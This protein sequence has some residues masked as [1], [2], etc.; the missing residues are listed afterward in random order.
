MSK[1]RWAAMSATVFGILVL[2]APQ[3]GIG[4][5][6]PGTKDFDKSGP[7]G[8]GPIMVGGPM[9]GQPRK[10][11]KDFDK[12]GDGRL[13]T[14]ERKAA[15]E[16]L[17]KDGR[18][19]GGF[20]KG[21]FGPPGMRGKQDPPKPGPKVSPADV[22]AYPD[23]PLY[24]SGVLRT[25]FLEFENKDWEA[26]LQ[27]FHNTD[28]EVPATL[29]VDGKKYP[30]VG[31]RFRGMTSYGGVPAGY[32]RPLNLSL[33][34][35]APGQRLYGYKTLNLLNAHEDPSF[36]S[37]VLYS[38]I[39]RKHI[40]APKANLVKVVIN[41]ESWGVYVSAQQFDKVF[42]QENFKTDQG[43]RWKVG[44]GPGG[45]GLE[46]VGENVADYK[47]RFELKSKDD[48]KAWKALINLCKVL[49]QTPAEKLEEA[50]SP[51]ID[52]DGLLWFL[53]L[54]VALVNGDGYWSR[55]CDY[56]LFLD[57]KGKFHVVPHDM[58]E[59]F[60]TGG[61]PGGGMM[62]IR[63]SR[64]GEILA[65][66]LQDMLG[67]TADQKKQVEALQRETEEKLA[68]ILTADQNKQV[69][70]MRDRGP[71]GFVFPGGGPGGPGGFGPKG[72]PPPGGPAAFV[73]AGAGGGGIDLDPLV[74]LTDTRK[75]LRSKVLA[76]PSLKAKY[77]AMVRKI[78][79]EDLNWKNLGPVV[80]SYRK[81]IEKEVEADT[82]KLDSFDA[83]QRATADTAT[84]GGRGREMPLRAFADGRRKYLLDYKEP[85]SA[86]GPTR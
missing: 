60:R 31:I 46:Y 54:D 78:A 73:P 20:G 80:A 27:D 64:P 74:G 32:K 39:A 85:K 48:E 16:S 69:K 30:N 52:V 18:G 41:G 72:G 28:V 34:P 65:A 51:I 40:P 24:D 35:S 15:R 29:T 42:V 25:L 86:A 37:T 67:L 58:N 61:G 59:A 2:A 45:G 79:D 43:T 77:L 4:Q 19:P 36:L 70:E 76:V 44:M 81:L 23:A 68:K 75:P 6:G 62:T 84:T 63:M 11:V 33:D 21:G 5:P 7:F 10:L 71:G 82:R 66:P 38:H 50:L 26:E 49:N 9:G 53:A 13:N 83:F 56:S 8:K 17:A 12:D 3:D 55:A 14:D 22:K 1:S 47:R 57:P